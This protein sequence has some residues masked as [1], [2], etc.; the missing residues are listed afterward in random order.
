M[1]TY[2]YIWKSED[3]IQKSVLS[4]HCESWDGTQAVRLVWQV[5]LPTKPSMATDFHL[6][7]KK[8]EA[9]LILCA[10]H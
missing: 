6:T 7:S 8:A 4:L 9:R 2:G 1:S 10:A 5:P 3:D